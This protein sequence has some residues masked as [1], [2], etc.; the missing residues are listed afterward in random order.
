[1][2]L[3][4]SCWTSMR[5]GRK[6]PVVSDVKLIRGTTTS[7]VPPSVE[8]V[9][10]S[11]DTSAGSLIMRDQSGCSHCVTRTNS[12]I[13]NA[14]NTGVLR[15]SR[16]RM[17]GNYGE[18]LTPLSAEIVLLTSTPRVRQMILPTFSSRRWRR[19]AQPLMVHHHRLLRIY[20]RRFRCSFSLHY[21]RTTWLS[22]C[23]ALLPSS[24][25][26]THLQ[27]GYLKTVSTCF[28]RT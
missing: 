19:Y 22:W 25:V 18:P 9:N 17:L 14:T 3:L 12:S 24:P 8:H 11:D 21:V 15:S 10:S 28:H 1:M 13:E 5:P 2:K 23:V 27:H 16:K 4:R 26:L 6:S 20:S 7:V